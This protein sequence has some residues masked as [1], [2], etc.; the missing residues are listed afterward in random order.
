MVANETEIVN[1]ALTHLGNQKITSIDGTDAVAVIAEEVYDQNRDYVLTLRE[2]GCATKRVHLVKASETAITGATAATPPVITCSGHSFTDGQLVSFSGVVG[3]TELNGIIF[4]VDD[5]ATDTFELQDMES[6]DI[7]GSGYTAYSS[8]G[9]VFLSPGEG[10]DY[11]YDLP[12]D[13]LKP[14]D[15]LDEDWQMPGDDTHY[16]YVQEGRVIYTNVEHAALKYIKKETDPTKYDSQL[17]DMMALRLAWILSN[18]ITGV[19]QSVR[20]DLEKQV[21]RMRIQAGLMDARAKRSRE[22][23]EKAWR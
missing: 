9:Y 16:Q 11:A 17:A 23:R 18:K 4:R 2:W 7:V 19:S 10:W 20:Q 15:I 21:Q 14:I 12:S 6:V 22:S 13:C 1:L 3:M 5:K 8:G